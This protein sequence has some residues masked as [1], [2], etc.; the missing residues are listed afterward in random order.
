M[1]HQLR[2]AARSI[3]I[4]VLA[5]VL[6]ACGATAGAVTPN[7]TGAMVA[8]ASS[9]PSSSPSASPAEGPVARAWARWQQ[10][11][12]GNYRYRH[13]LPAPGIRPRDTTFAGPAAKVRATFDP[14]LGYPLSVY[15]DW[16]EQTA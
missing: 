2:P 14:E 10:H 11:R 1:P 9:S 8:T 5:L 3:T 6:A 4:P 12:A 13:P 7:P 16:S 15:I